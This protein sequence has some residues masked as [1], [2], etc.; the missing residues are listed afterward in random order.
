MILFR[1]L[2]KYIWNKFA[3]LLPLSLVY[4]RSQ[5]SSF[6]PWQTWLHSQTQAAGSITIDWHGQFDPLGVDM[7][8]HSV[9]SGHGLSVG[10]SS[11]LHSGVVHSPVSGHSV[12]GGHSL[13]QHSISRHGTVRHSVVE[14]HSE[15]VSHVTSGHWDVLVVSGV[16]IGGDHSPKL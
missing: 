16:V 3:D 8:G 10:Q 2:F 9:V 15:H 11:V 14:S 5:L 1:Q 12:V 13:D 6:D 7:D 4:T